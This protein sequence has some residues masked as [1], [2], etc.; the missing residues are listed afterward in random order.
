MSDVR[1][2]PCPAPWCGSTKIFINF[3]LE[4]WAMCFQCGLLGPTRKTREEAISAWNT[5]PVNPLLEQMAKVLENYQNAV[6]D[7]AGVY[8]RSEDHVPYA[9]DSSFFAPP[10]PEPRRF[11]DTWPFAFLVV[12]AGVCAVFGLCCLLWGGA[13]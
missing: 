10:E 7:F 12:I 9:H 1:L 2:L 13:K 8:D 6:A 4:Y 5:R 11:I 3:G